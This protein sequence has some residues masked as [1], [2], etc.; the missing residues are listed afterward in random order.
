MVP[1]FSI[2]VSYRAAPLSAA[3]PMPPSG[4]DGI[5]RVICFPASSTAI[6]CPGVPEPRIS[7]V[8]FFFVRLQGR[9]AIGSDSDAVIRR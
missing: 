3:T 2:T 9:V 8:L 6:P 4:R 5:N 1:F 7:I